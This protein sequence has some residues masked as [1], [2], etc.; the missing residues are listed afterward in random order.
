MFR[1]ISVRKTKT[2]AQDRLQKLVKKKVFAE[3]VKELFNE[4]ASANDKKKRKSSIENLSAKKPCTSAKASGDQVDLIKSSQ[5]VQNSDTTSVDVQLRVRKQSI[6][7]IKNSTPEKISTLFT[8][9]K[10][11]AQDR[12]DTVRRNALTNMNERDATLFQNSFEVS[13]TTQSTDTDN[14]MDEEMEWEDCGE[15]VDELTYSFQELEDMVVEVLADSSNSAFIV[16]DTNVF[17]DSLAPIKC[18]MEKGLFFT[19][20]RQ[21]RIKEKTFHYRSKIQYSCSIC[22]SARIGQLEEQT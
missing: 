1:I 3:N 4:T 14:N 22:G 11:P 2:P 19:F 16:P 21:T 18:V 7:K 9:S 20:S 12:L 17:L 10:T 5:I 13:N 6:T 8:S 15:T